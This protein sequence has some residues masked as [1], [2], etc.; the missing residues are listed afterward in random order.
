M[1]IKMLSNTV[2]NGSSAKINEVVDV[3]ELDGKMLIGMKRA[4]VFIAYKQK[5][6]RKIRT[7]DV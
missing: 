3:S 2:V 6:K 4:E 5:A 7:H 1:K